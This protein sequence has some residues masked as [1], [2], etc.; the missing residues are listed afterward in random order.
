M[1][2][3]ERK[4]GLCA[5]N[6][7][8][9]VRLTV[10]PL[11]GGAEEGLYA[12]FNVAEALYISP[13]S[14]THAPPIR[15]LLFPPAAG[16]AGGRSGGSSSNASSKMMVAFGRQAGTAAAGVEVPSSVGAAAASDA[17]PHPI[18]H[19]FCDQ[20]RD[21]SDLLV[22]MANGEVALMSLR[23]QIRNA[24]AAVVAGVAAAAQKDKA[25]DDNDKGNDNTNEA[26]ADADDAAAAATTDKKK[27]SKGSSSSTNPPKS[28]PAQ[29]AQQAAMAVKPTLTAM[30]NPCDTAY[31]SSRVVAV[32][33]VPGTDGLRF[34]VAHASGVVGL[35]QKNTALVAASLPKGAPLPKGIPAPHPPPFSHHNLALT[36]AAEKGRS[37]LSQLSAAAQR[38]SG[39][40][41]DLIA[42]DRGP[43]L[44]AHVVAPV[45]LVRVPGGGINDMAFS[46]DGQR[47]AVA[48]RDGALRIYDYRKAM[49]DAFIAAEAVS[50]PAPSGEDY[51]D[52]EST[53][54]GG[55]SASVRLGSR[56]GPNDKGLGLPLPPLP[57]L[58]QPHV[59][60]S[61][62][63]SGGVPAIQLPLVGG[64]R[65][66][67]GGVLCC[68]WSP[69]G[70]YL[71]AGGEDDSVA[72]YCVADRAV[73][74]WGE[75]HD[76]WVS[77]VAF[78]PLVAGN[79]VG[80]AA[81]AG[82]LM[83]MVGGEAGGGASAAAGAP[84]PP[85][86]TTT[87]ASGTI[88]RQYRIASGGQDC[89]VCLWDIVIEEDAAI[90]GAGGTNAPGTDLKLAPLG[91]LPVAGKIA[92]RGGAGGGG[93]GAGGEGGGVKRVASSPNVAVPT[94]SS[95][96][97]LAALADEQQQQLAVGPPAPAPAP[98]PMPAAVA[99][100]P[101]P[102]PP[103]PAAAADTSA[104]A[105][106]P[107]KKKKGSASNIKKKR[108]TAEELAAAAREAHERAAA[109]HAEARRLA[110]AEEALVKKSMKRGGKS[111]LKAVAMREQMV[112]APSARR[113]D[114]VVIPPAVGPHKL[115]VLPVSDV[116]FSDEAVLTADH[117]GVVRTWLRP[118]VAKALLEGGGGGGGGGR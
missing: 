113:G 100:P 89:A 32:A 18:C 15:R 16:D 118:S 83:M 29:L 114:S 90:L 109:A 91:E 73:V 81:A 97:A 30:L 20:A 42:R 25:G 105:A 75:G 115:H 31:D 67:Y 112:L 53:A 52:D 47:L 12:V 84:P 39:G 6:S 108:Q 59:T 63:P 1:L 106:A 54:F 64:Y 38:A 68:A 69:D 8:R 7:R 33:W 21:G 27:G 36:Q 107:P 3:S 13:F 26:E 103:P 101:P 96:A 5:Y 93:A 10:A 99:A 41:A 23:E 78:D 35:Y 85:T 49:T 110:V 95:A 74:A 14:E 40:G 60:S 94:V 51:P 79:G 66:Y 45:A 72:V 24:P 58:P 77:R 44:P 43:Q 80:S 92:M 17:A 28:T 22:G 86:T 104:P 116:V 56:A 62:G 82:G 48:C 71:A 34:A 55:S 2:H 102:P 98:A 4:E 19:A 76:A 46:P 65:S 61:A 88:E 57:P 50:V 9:P 37:L 87:T 70:R 117:A 11:I 111:L